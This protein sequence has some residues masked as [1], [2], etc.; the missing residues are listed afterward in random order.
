MDTRMH[1]EAMPNADRTGL[2][3]PAMVAETIASMI[4]QARHIENGERLVA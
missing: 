4:L 1:A 3:S 2:Q